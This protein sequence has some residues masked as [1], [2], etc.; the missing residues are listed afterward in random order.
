MSEPIETY[1]IPCHNCRAPFDALA[2]PWCSCLV[3]ERTVVCPSCLTCFC[4]AAPAYKHQFWSGAPKVLWDA[5][6][7]E[8]NSEFETK[9][10]PDP[11]TALRPL[12]LVVDDERNI[13]RM[14]ARVIESLGY[15]MILARDGVE[16]RNLARKY[17]PDLVLSDALMPKLDGREMCRQLKSEKSTAHLKVIVMTALYTSVKYRNEGFKAYQVDDYLSKPVDFAQLRAVLEKHL[18]PRGSAPG[19]KG[20]K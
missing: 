16:G 1:E 14:A 13:Q 7:N 12:V 19:D 5:K 4:K 6:W 9:P 2:A 18:T 20:L 3:T 8:H 17:L 11:E 10:N 15:G